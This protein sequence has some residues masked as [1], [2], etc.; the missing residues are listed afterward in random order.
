[1]DGGGV[2][3]G[4][5]VQWDHEQGFWELGMERYGG[6]CVYEPLENLNPSNGRGPF[7]L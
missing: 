3:R 2:V 1:M 5:G 6:V 4:G 7:P